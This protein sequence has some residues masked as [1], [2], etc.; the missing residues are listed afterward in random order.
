MVGRW[1]LE[2]SFG[3]VPPIIKMG[4]GKE[5]VERTREKGRWCIF[6]FREAGNKKP[7]ATFWVKFA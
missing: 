4:L 2:K 5:K 1:V 7:E 3:V 6:E